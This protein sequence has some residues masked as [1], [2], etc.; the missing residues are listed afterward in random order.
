[1]VDGVADYRLVDLLPSPFTLGA[2]RTLGPPTGERPRLYVDI[3]NVLCRTDERIRQLICE[4]SSGRVNYA[5]ED[6]LEFDYRNC[7]VSGP[8]GEKVAVTKLV[9]RV[10]H[11]ERF[12]RPE[13]VSGLVPMP[14]AT[15]EMR[16]LKDRFDVAYITGRKPRLQE[17]TQHWLTSNGFPDGPVLFANR[18]QKHLVVTGAFALVEDDLEQTEP[19][20]R[21]GMHAVLLAHPWNKTGPSSLCHRCLDWAAVS[22]LFCQLAGIC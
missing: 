1:M 11:V 5:Y 20:A 17:A 3:D 22:A 19:A 14:G 10:A 2:A 13:V 15:E 8:T 16:R 9:W 7:T 12:S 6:I 18:G 4:V 21:A